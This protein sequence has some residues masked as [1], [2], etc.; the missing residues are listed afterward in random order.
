MIRIMIAVGM[1]IAWIASRSR[2]RQEFGPPLIL[3]P[4]PP[5]QF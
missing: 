3:H 1:A 4:N 5:R 2:I